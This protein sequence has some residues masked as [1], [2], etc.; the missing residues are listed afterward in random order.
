[1]VQPVQCLR[2]SAFMPSLSS[3]R[4]SGYTLPSGN[5]L[6]L[7]LLLAVECHQLT[8]RQVAAMRF[9][10][11]AVL[12]PGIVIHVEL[13]FIVPVQGAEGAR[14]PAF[15]L[16]A[17]VGV[18]RQRCGRSDGLLSVQAQVERRPLRRQIRGYGL[19]SRTS[20]P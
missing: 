3:W 5:S 4:I 14:A 15:H 10:E 9:V 16:A 7:K 18:G 6:A 8:V 19:P 17:G 12:E 2:K 20:E 13:V 11:P 1:M